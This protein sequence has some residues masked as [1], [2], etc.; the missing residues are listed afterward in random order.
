MRCLEEASDRDAFGMTPLFGA[1]Q[2]RTGP[3]EDPGLV[4]GITGHIH[5][6]RENLKAPQ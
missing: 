6:A 4:G 1:C 5:L 2:T 3:V